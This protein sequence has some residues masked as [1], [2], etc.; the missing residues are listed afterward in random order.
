MA[1]KVMFLTNFR[2]RVELV[3]DALF[4]FEKLY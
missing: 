4:F 2:P 3:R 1:T